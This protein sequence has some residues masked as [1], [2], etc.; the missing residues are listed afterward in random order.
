MIFVDVYTSQGR[1]D[2]FSVRG[3]AG[4]AESGSDIVCAAVSILIYNAVNS[5]ERFAGAEL[6]VADAGDEFVCTVPEV[7]WSDPVK[8]LLSS[9]VFGVEQ[10][11]EQYPEYICLRH[12][13][14]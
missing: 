8:L 4:Y 12:H 7:L 13:S 3:H 1:I 2:R 5:C 6:A 10:L 14:Q 9:M 11:T